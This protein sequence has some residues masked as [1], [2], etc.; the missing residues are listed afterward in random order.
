M[1]SGPTGQGPR[2]PAAG[3]AGQAAL[4][5]VERLGQLAERTAEL[6]ESNASVKELL[7]EATERGEDFRA[8][9]EHQ[10]H[11][12]NSLAHEV[13]SPLTACD[14]MLDELLSD[15]GLEGA[16]AENV[17][18]ARQCIAEAVRIVKDQLQRARLEA[19]VLRPRLDRVDVSELY[20]ALRGMVRALRRS[21]AVALEFEA[22]DDLPELHT[23]PHMLGQILRNLMGNAL[24]F[25]NAGSVSVRAAFDPATREFTFEV[26]DTGLGIPEADRERIFEDFG[27]VESGPSGGRS[28][29]GLG[30]PLSRSLAGALGGSLELAES[31]GPGL[32]FIVR[33]PERAPAAVPS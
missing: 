19:G 23:D 1:A 26:S 3:A 4:E 18:D 8:A 22:A 6:E 9:A 30:L 17:A 25:T 7:A 29:T 24:K 32:T 21:D 10:R 2:L 5:A 15:F 12:L 31:D 16:A 27:Q 11:L 14:L 13:R 33:L 28:G 20:L